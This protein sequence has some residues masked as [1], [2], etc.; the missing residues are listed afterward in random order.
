MGEV[1]SRVGYIGYNKDSGKCERRHPT[2]TAKIRVSC[3]YWNFN[4]LIVRPAIQTFNESILKL[5]MRSTLALLA[6]FVPAAMAAECAP[7]HFVY[8]RATTEPPKGLTSAD[9]TGPDGVAKFDKAASGIWSL[10]YGA[11]GASL[12]SN[13]T[14]LLPGTT[15]WP[16]HYPASGEGSKLGVQDMFDQVSKQSKACPKQLFALGG[17]SQGGFVTNNTL[18][19]IFTPELLAKVVAVA[20]FGSPACPPQVKGR[21]NSYCN[22]GDFV[23][24]PSPML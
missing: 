2:S 21:C 19:S 20:M 1:Q 24:G 10:G 7:L 23:R 22:K 16:V 8:A 4:S 5:K 6:A 14:K 11:A 3:K 13:I 17:H 9:L 15:G 18:S 12:F